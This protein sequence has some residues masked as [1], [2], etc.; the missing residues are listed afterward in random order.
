M[1]AATPNA[2]S[3]E[4]SAPTGAKPSTVPLSA[5][6]RGSS[7]RVVAVVGDDA[8]AHRLSASG[9]WPGVVVERLQHAPFGDPQLFRLHGYRLALRVA[10]AA[11]VE[12]R[13]LVEPGS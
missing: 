2:P 5:L 11:R 4:P 7:A 3:Q 13:P 9:L 1:T 10:E 8:L 12:V 6:S